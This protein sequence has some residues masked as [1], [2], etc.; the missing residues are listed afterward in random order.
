PEGNLIYSQL[1]L[2]PFSLSSQFNNGNLSNIAGA[3]AAAVAPFGNINA[4]DPNLVVPYQMN[5]S[6][7]VQRQLPWGIFGEAAYVGNLG[8]HL[9][10]QPDINQPSF[11]VIAANAGKLSLNALRPYKGYSAILMRLSDSNSNY[12]ALQL[13]A[14]KRKGDLLMTAGYTWSK[15]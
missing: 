7:S 8:G 14:T 12:N 3:A 10:R 9:I 15:V 13:Y 11:D 4:L 2:P 6:L 5:F 1:N